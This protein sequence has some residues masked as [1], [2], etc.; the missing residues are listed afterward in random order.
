MFHDTGLPKTSQKY[1]NFRDYPFPVHPFK[2][3]RRFAQQNPDQS[4]ENPY[5]STSGTIINFLLS[6]VCDR[7]LLLVLQIKRPFSRLQI[8]LLRAGSLRHGKRFKLSQLAKSLEFLEI[9]CRLIFIWAH[10]SALRSR[11]FVLLRSAKRA[12]LRSGRIWVLKKINFK[13]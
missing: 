3:A 6:L 10:I 11:F 8:H 4:R 1:K 13:Q 9:Y 12:P 2:K 7:I 5:A